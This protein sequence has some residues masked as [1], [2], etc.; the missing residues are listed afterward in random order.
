M[1]L[2]FFAVRI[3]RSFKRFYNGSRPRL[4]RST[5]LSLCCNNLAKALANMRRW[6]FF[7]KEKNTEVLFR[8]SANDNDRLGSRGLT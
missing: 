2:P 7:A 5:L 8:K 6:A 1:D 4:A 3:L